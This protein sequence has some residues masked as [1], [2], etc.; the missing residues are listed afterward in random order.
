[1]Q[2]PSEN[3]A[4]ESPL[5]HTPRLLVSLATYNEHDNLAPLIEAIHQQAANADV[6]VIDDNS[7]D[8]TGRLADELAARDSRIH[9]LHRPGKLGLGTATLAGMRYAIDNNYDLFLN[10]DADFSHP[11]RYIP[12]LLEGMK[13]HDIM[14]G[15]R[16]VKGGGTMNWPLTRRM[17]SR[18][19]NVMVR[20]LFRMPVKDASGAFRCFRVSKLRQVPTD[21]IRSRGYSFQQE[22]LY[23]CRRAGCTLGEYPII[24][25]NRRAGA[26]KVNMKEAVRS[27]SMLMWLGMR[28]R[29]GMDR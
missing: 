15:S 28:S 14:I 27:I 25:E 20:F 3:G 4:T 12:H 8:G 6:L 24:F 10:L 5:P 9:V 21:R 29:L 11:P 19:V 7:P 18:S 22:M 26:S 17:I 23:R 16:Y 2:G 13:D 1:M